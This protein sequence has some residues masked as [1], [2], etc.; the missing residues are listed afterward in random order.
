MNFLGETLTVLGFASDRNT[1]FRRR[2][3]IRT[4]SRNILLV[5]PTKWLFGCLNPHKR[6]EAP[7]N[8][9][10]CRLMAWR[11]RKNAGCVSSYI[12][13]IDLSVRLVFLKHLILAA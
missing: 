11:Q 12:Y 7:Q 13:L 1:E 8:L 2:K 5:N 6:L 4:R 3:F 10:E 9:Y